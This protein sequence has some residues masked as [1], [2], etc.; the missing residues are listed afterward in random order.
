MTST[1]SAW[2]QT[3]EAVRDLHRTLVNEVVSTPRLPKDDIEVRDG[4]EPGPMGDFRWADL[5][6]PGG[7]RRGYRGGEPDLFDERIVPPIFA[8]APPPNITSSGAGS[9]QAVAE[10]DSRSRRARSAETSSGAG[11]FSWRTRAEQFLADRARPGQVTFAAT[12]SSSAARNRTRSPRTGEHDRGGIG[13]SHDPHPSA[14]FLDDL[15]PKNPLPPASSLT[16]L[17]DF[18]PAE[19]QEPPRNSLVARLIDFNRRLQAEDDEDDDELISTLT[20]APASWGPQLLRFDDFR[21]D[22]FDATIGKVRARHGHVV[23]R[24]DL[25]VRATVM[26]L[27][28]LFFCS[29]I[30]FM[31]RAYS[32]GGVLFSVLCISTLVMMTTLCIL[33]LIELRVKLAP[34]LE[35]RGWLAHANYGDVAGVTI[36]ANGKRIVDLSLFLS[37]A[38][39]GMT[40]PVVIAQ[41][42]ARGVFGL[43]DETTRCDIF[44]G[45]NKCSI[46][47]YTYT[48][49]S[50]VINIKII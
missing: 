38:S 44:C 7:F 2:A 5:A 22:L 41:C 27:L 3:N 19:P 1:S 13:V 46:H 11:D 10:E 45:I 29:G 36:G 34:E 43:Q 28:K 20:S 23:P 21:S 9:R 48:S 33:Q 47:L 30:L 37:Q 15:Q 25:S 31:P 35:E 50:V 12:T 32:N 26:S 16:L 14:P 6:Q 17:D 18:L 24:G 42:F 40:Y 8:A 49:C 39:Y 4:G